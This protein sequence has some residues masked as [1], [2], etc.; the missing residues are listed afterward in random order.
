MKE[1][2]L[3]KGHPSAAR[4][5]LLPAAILAI[6][7][8]SLLSACVTVPVNE[9]ASQSSEAPLLTRFKEMSADEIE[10]A[11]DQAWRDGEL[12]RAVFIYMQSLDKEE[13]PGV[14]LK[15]GRIQHYSGQTVAAW[16]AFERAIELDPKNP[17]AHEQLGMLYVGSKQKE[18]AVQHLEKAVRLDPTRWRARNA[19]G[20]LA[21]AGGDYQRAI[22]HYESALEQRPQSAM[23]MT[24]LGYSH[25]LAGD[26][27]EAERLFLVAIGLDR[28]YEPAIA[29]LGLVRARR[30]EYDS[31]VE[32]LENIM[33]RAKALNDVGYIAFVNDDIAE[34]ERLLGDA[35][36]ASPTY[37]ETAYENLERVQDA[38]KSIRP[39][40]EEFNAATG[41]DD[42]GS[43][44][45]EIRQVVTA[46][47]NVRRSDSIDAPIVGFLAAENRV[48]VLR[49][50]GAWSFV[51]SDTDGEQKPV[52]G[53]VLSGFLVEPR[54]ESE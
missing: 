23:L 40:A 43:A 34:A 31:A 35:V 27:D 3:R 9:S 52:I 10:A 20:V 16:Q 7:A 47:L 44:P 39:R 26:L 37:Y 22:G 50:K 17:E 29:N 42:P 21:D 25:Y 38:Q 14:W 30:G 51:A 8:G 5:R 46:R 11:G 28:N 53:W 32:V 36:Q 24:N 45:A 41:G 19:L 13:D 6:A 54:D 4:R 15:V 49:D 12:E 1:T 2:G 18:L 33:D 48:R